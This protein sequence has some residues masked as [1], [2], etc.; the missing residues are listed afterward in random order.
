[1]CLPVLVSA[2]KQFVCGFMLFLQVCGGNPGDLLRAAGAFGLHGDWEPGK[3][4]VTDA[5]GS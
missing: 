5:V 1:M 2:L 4:S 3:C